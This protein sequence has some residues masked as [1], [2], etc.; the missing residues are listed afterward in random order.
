MG[1]SLWLFLS[2]SHQIPED[3]EFIECIWTSPTNGAGV[4]THVRLFSSEP[5]AWWTAVGSTFFLR[6][7]RCSYAERA[8]KADPSSQ[9][10]CFLPFGVDL[11]WG[12]P[13]QCSPAPFCPYTLSSPHLV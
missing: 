6:E 4:W 3:K 12:Q 8:K 1:E 10:K 11:V 9:D 2:S 7:L 5:W 13:S